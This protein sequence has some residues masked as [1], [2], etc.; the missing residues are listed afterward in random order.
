M[1]AAAFHL[2]LR[3]PTRGACG[4]CGGAGR[5][6]EAGDAATPA[7]LAR[8]CSIV[9]WADALFGAAPDAANVWIGGS[10]SVTSLHQDWYENM[11]I[12]VRGTKRFALVPPTDCQAVP[13]QAI[14]EGRY[15]Y[16]PE[17]GTFSVEMLAPGGGPEG[18]KPFYWVDFDETVARSRGAHV[19]HV[20]LHAGDVLYL[21]AAWY[22][23]VSQRENMIDADADRFVCAVNFWYDMHYGHMFYLQQLMKHTLG[24]PDA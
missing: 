3:A 2:A 6:H 4:V 16:D 24:H 9:A 20:T 10:R 15:R 1:G 12:V 11:Y 5:G 17:A 19:Y 21:P 8:S 14:P 13:K 22:H 23:E 7:A 18:L